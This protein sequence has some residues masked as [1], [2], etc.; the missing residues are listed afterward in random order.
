M[1]RL[2]Y[3][4]EHVSLFLPFNINC[5][6]VILLYSPSHSGDISP[7]ISKYFKEHSARFAKY[8]IFRNTLMT[9]M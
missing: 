6:T 4:I 7:S 3:E 2:Q 1:L 5:L 9:N 8:S